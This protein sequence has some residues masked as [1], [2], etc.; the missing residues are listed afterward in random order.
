[1]CNQTDHLWKNILIYNFLNVLLFIIFAP[2]YVNFCANI[3]LNAVI[4]MIFF[5]SLIMELYDYSETL[6]FIVRFYS[7]M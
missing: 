2:S 5:Y 6:D 7:F 1:M 4:C 3:A